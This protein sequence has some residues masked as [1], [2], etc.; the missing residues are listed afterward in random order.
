MG[1]RVEGVRRSEDLIPS[2]AAMASLNACVTAESTSWC[3]TPKADAGSIQLADN[4]MQ[5]LAG[6]HS[7]R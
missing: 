4:E 7:R 3:T 6:R 1:R 5:L 2:E